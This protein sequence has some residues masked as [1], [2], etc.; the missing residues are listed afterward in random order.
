MKKNIAEILED[1]HEGLQLWSPAYGKVE[2]KKATDT[3]VIIRTKCGYAQLN[4]DGTLSAD[5]ECMLFPSPEQRDWEEFR[6]AKEKVEKFDINT[7]KPFDR[8][9]A[10]DSNE[11]LWVIELWMAYTPQ[12][13]KWKYQCLGNT[14]DQCIPYEGNEHLIVKADMPDEYYI[15]WEEEK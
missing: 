12:Y 4:V 2:L 14:Y 5:G 6:K 3:G 1:Q 8:V 15:T 10:R 13:K 9:L 7:L 11:A